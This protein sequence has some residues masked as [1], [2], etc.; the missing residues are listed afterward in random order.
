MAFLWFILILNMIANVDRAKECFF[1]LL[2]DN[3]I[4]SNHLALEFHVTNHLMR[5]LLVHMILLSWTLYYV[6]TEIVIYL[7][8]VFLLL[9]TMGQ[10]TFLLY[11]WVIF[12]HIVIIYL[13]NPKVTYQTVNTCAKCVTAGVALFTG[14][15]AYEIKTASVAAVNSV[16]A[17]A[18]KGAS[19]SVKTKYLGDWTVNIPGTEVKKK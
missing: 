6:P 8:F 11:F 4:I 13:C 10:I 17:T 5:A 9:F 1:V 12:V 18:S 3:S 16:A 14:Y 15:Q 19:V 7:P 2:Q